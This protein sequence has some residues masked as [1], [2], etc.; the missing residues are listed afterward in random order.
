MR[1]LVTADV[2]ADWAKRTHFSRFF[3]TLASRARAEGCAYVI[4][5]GDLWH[6]QY[7][8]NVEFFLWLRKALI[9]MKIKLILIRG[10]HELSTKSQPEI[11][12]IALFADC[13]NIRVI[14]KPEIL[15]APDK[16]YALY[17]LP[18]YLPDP[19]I[20]KVTELKKLAQKDGRNK[21][22]LTHIGLKEGKVSASNTYTVNQKTTIEHLGYRYYDYCLM[23]DYHRRQ[24]LARNVWYLGAPIALAHGDSPNQG[25]WLLDIGR[26]TTLTQLEFECGW[27]AFTTVSITNED[28]LHRLSE[29]PLE[30]FVRVRATP[31]FQEILRHKY[32]DAL[33]EGIPTELIDVATGRLEGVAQDDPGAVFQVW[34]RSAG[35]EQNRPLQE[36]AFQYIQRVAE[37]VR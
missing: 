22:L 16:S 19:W 32:P 36:M 7:K 24:K 31:Q 1:A 18:W 5:V 4:I 14:N 25:V 28:E 33:I 15:A 10:N 17:C 3:K 21:V 30:G 12:L 11:S 34:A 37:G 6:E 20:E 9:G 8:T 2:H 23:G 26:G 27:P 13:P 29:N 35:H